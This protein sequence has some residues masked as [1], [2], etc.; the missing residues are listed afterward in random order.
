VLQPASRTS[1]LRRYLPEAVVGPAHR[2]R[3]EAVAF[4]H[5]ASQPRRWLDVARSQ[6]ARGGV[7]V[8]YGYER[9]PTDAD[10]VYGGLVKFQELSQALP[11]APRDFNVLYLGSTALPLD[12]RVLLALA[13]RRGAAF[14]WNQNGVCY[15]AWFGPGCERLNRPRARLM[16][17]A[18][19]VIYQSAFCKLAA[20]RWYGGRDER[21]EVLHNPVDV[22]RFTPAGRPDNG[23]PTL[24]LGGNQ[25]QRY[26]LDTALSTLAEVRRTVPEARLLVAGAIAWHEDRSVASRETERLVHDLGLDGAV[27][28]VGPYAR[29]D[30]PAL[31]RRA[32]VLLH[33][34]VNDPCPTIVLEAMACGLPV[35]YAASGGTPELVGGDAGVGVPSPLDWEQDHAPSPTELAAAVADVLGRLPDLRDV[36]RA[37][38]EE[39]GLTRWVARHRALFEELT[40]R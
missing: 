3:D 4:A 12:A 38:A 33:T 2:A 15:P 28:F 7:R 26:R 25:Y 34:K 31:M 16:H 21:W 40:A 32:D 20:D 17:A 14:V 13:R 5:T 8:S 18:D 10:V 19:H 9:M 6:P 36:A 37:R 24:L 29:R 23:S 35:V 30:A 27:D 11:N 39:F 22:E 1:R